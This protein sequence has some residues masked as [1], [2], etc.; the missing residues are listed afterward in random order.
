M[1]VHELASWAVATRSLDSAAR[2][3]VYAVIAD[4]IGSTL[5]GATLGGSRAARAAAPDL[6][7]RGDAS[8]WFS[9]E[10]A[11][12]S[13]A[14]FANAMAASILDIDDGHRAAAGHPGAGIVPAVLGAARALEAS[15]ED[16][17]TAVAIGYEVGLRIGA[18]RDL[19]AIDTLITGRWC[20][21][22]IAAA[23]GWLRGRPMDEIAEAIAIAGAVAPWMLVAEYTQVGN[24][25]K[26]AIPFGAANGIIAA[27]LAERGF[28][29]PVDI[30]D[31]EYYDAAILKDGAKDGRLLVQ[32]TYFK[33]YSC[34]RWAHASI[35]AILDMVSDG[36]DWRAID[37]IEAHT[38]GRTLSLNNQPHPTTIQAAQYSVPFCIAAAAVGGISAV[39]P[40]TD[41]LLNNQEIHALAERVKLIVDPDLDAAFPAAVPGRLVVLSGNERHVRQVDSPK[42]EPTNPMSWEE[43]TAK[44]R[45]LGT[46]RL[47]PRQLETLLGATEDLHDEGRLAPLYECLDIRI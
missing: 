40:M 7:G 41:D 24:H 21:Q 8:I 3:A 22:G 14:A 19:R 11:S 45:T 28:K 1:L 9:G 6:W 36:L 47:E 23:V 30:L 35:D 27:G 2:E 38:F 17:L 44:L 26:E 15:D 32:T 5:I 37:T 25:T 13:G 39:Q 18:S 29:G 33:P 12:L 16:T 4:A 20:G 31:H 34:C 43:I 42:G 46:G 10:T